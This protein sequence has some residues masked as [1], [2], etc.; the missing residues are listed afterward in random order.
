MF[1]KET[2]EETKKAV[3]RFLE[4]HST[5]EFHLLPDALKTLS[6]ISL[7]EEERKKVLSLVDRSVNQAK[8]SPLLPVEN[9]RPA[10]MLQL[11]KF[12]E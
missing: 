4:H 3:F 1:K 2:E 5:A 8:F 6:K 12:F 9:N 10:L 7:S 11:K